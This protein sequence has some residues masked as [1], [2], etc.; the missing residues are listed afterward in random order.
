MQCPKICR[1]QQSVD[2]EASCTGK[3]HLLLF[4]QSHSAAGL[5]ARCS[6]LPQ[7]LESSSAQKA[8]QLQSAPCTTLSRTCVLA[9]VSLQVL[10]EVVDDGHWDDVADVLATGQ[11]LEGNAHLQD[12]TDATLWLLTV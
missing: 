5:P 10:Q 9:A 1:G 11:A 3:Q 4:D 12:A 6:F 2:A 7:F 8:E